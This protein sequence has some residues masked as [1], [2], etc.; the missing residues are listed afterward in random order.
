MQSCGSTKYS[1]DTLGKEETA[2]PFAMPASFLQDVHGELDNKL[3]GKDSMGD[4]NF[5]AL[6][7]DP[8]S[9]EIF[10][11]FTD[12]TFELFAGHTVTRASKFGDTKH[13]HCVPAGSD[14]E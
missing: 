6:C 14:Q 1:G 4:R 3:P 9:G 7:K 10:D 13:F 5:L 8:T 11:A 12:Q 2:V